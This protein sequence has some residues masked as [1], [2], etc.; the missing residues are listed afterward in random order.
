[1]IIEEQ[2]K[3]DLFV[4]MPDTSRVWVYQANRSLTQNEVEQ[5][6][7]KAEAFVSGWE[8][9]GAKLKAEIAVLYNYFVVI[10]VDEEIHQASGCSIDKSVHFI[11]S[12]ES[13]TSVGFFDRTKIAVLND[14]NEIELLS[15][16]NVNIS[17]SEGKINDNTIIFNNLIEKLSDFR[18]NWQT[19]VKSS[20]L[21]RL[22]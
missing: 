8:S 5:I 4:N 11:K 16:S 10:V 17:F 19:P 14:L 2:T 18:N 1:M 3:K 7:Q 15:I 6:E 12:I 9:H 13:I 22:C 21:A 20:W